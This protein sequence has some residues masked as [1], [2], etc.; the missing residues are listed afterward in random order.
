MIRCS[1]TKNDGQQCTRDVSQK[2]GQNQQFCWQHQ[3]CSKLALLDLQQSIPLKK[4][5][6]PLKKEAIPLKKEALPLKK[7]SME[8]SSIND[9]FLDNQ[10]PVTPIN[11]INLESFVGPIPNSNWVIRNKILVGCYPLSQIQTLI[12]LGLT[13]I[14]SLQTPYELKGFDS[15][16]PMINLPQIKYYNF[17]IPDRKVVN[18]QLMTQ[19]M[20]QILSIVQGGGGSPTKLVYIHCKGGHGRTGVVVS[21]MLGCFYQLSSQQALELT[22]KLHDARFLKTGKIATNPYVYL[23]PQTK[24]QINQVKRLL[25]LIQKLDW[26]SHYSTDL[27]KATSPVKA[28]DQAKSID[29]EGSIKE[30]RF[31]EPKQPYY[32]FSNFYGTKD[33]KKYQLLID[34]QNWHSTE[35][36]YQANKFLGKDAT[37]ESIQYA[38]LIAITDTP[39][40]AYVL[41]RQ[42]KLGGYA[43]NWKHSKENQQT[44]T[45]I[46]AMSHVQGVKMR[47]DWDQVKDEIMLR[48]NRAKYQQNK[49]LADLLISTGNAKLIE[50]T[51]RD[52]YWGDGGDGS[53]LN[54]LGHILMLIRDELSK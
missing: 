5:P 17:P 49:K 27:I 4:Q 31:Y 38:Q 7:Q 29:F 13:E 36:Y 2:P 25:P 45:E 28:I 15:Y 53:G 22:Q 14:I 42:K 1:C 32:E 6:L 37:P 54:K 33:N 48:A 10:L 34:G 35:H 51:A 8:S 40:K 3:D 30:I 26:C 52:K 9:F 50:H 39:N 43:T 19:Y 23:S 44:L 18:D 11:N 12:D 20:D 41:A 16:L 46:I 47:H 21:L 24:I